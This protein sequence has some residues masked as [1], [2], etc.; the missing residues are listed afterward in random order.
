[1]VNPNSRSVN[2]R[3]FLDWI[4]RGVTGSIA[5]VLGILG[6]GAALSVPARRQEDGW[7]D[8]GAL[9]AILRGRPLEVALSVHRED[10]YRTMLDRR[11]VYLVRDGDAIRAYS[12]T[13]T[14]LGCRVSWHDDAGEFRC[15]CHGG[16]FTRTGSVAGGPPPRPL[17]EVAVRLDAGRVFLRVG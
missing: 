6:G 12:A 9:E 3:R 10:G 1:M 2:R 4:V 14:H 13:C 5:A 11:V 16:R 15:P 17:D 7:V 8:A